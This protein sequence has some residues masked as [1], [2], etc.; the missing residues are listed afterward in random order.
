MNIIK[1]QFRGKNSVC[2]LW[3]ENIYPSVPFC[4]SKTNLRSEGYDMSPKDATYQEAIYEW[5]SES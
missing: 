5:N 1:V 2:G 3:M 4:C